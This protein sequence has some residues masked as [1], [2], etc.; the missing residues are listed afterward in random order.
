MPDCRR[1]EYDESLQEALSVAVPT[2]SALQTKDLIYSDIER[3]VTQCSV[4]AQNWAPNDTAMGA[5][6]TVWLC[7]TLKE[8]SKLRHQVT[9]QLFYQ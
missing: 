2:T 4:L 3:N 8:H 9:L 1:F 7:H 5:S 6:L